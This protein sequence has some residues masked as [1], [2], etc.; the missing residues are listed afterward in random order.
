MVFFVRISIH[1]WPRSVQH[2]Y[3]IQPSIVDMHRSTA[4]NLR[5]VK[6]LSGQSHVAEDRNHIPLHPDS[7][8]RPQAHYSHFSCIYTRSK[9]QYKLW[10]GLGRRL[11]SH[12]FSIS[13][14]LLAALIF[15]PCSVQQQRDKEIL[16]H[17]TRHAP[18]PVHKSNKDNV[19]K[20][21]KTR[22][23]STSNILYV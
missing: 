17:S 7:R 15:V 20:R 12:F 2:F 16:Q 21:K 5:A 9:L 1:P 10:A 23:T 18:S 19:I 14:S 6:L 11:Q 22:I 4:A 8:D 3:P 13:D